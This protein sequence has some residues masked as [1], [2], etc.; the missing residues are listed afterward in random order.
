EPQRRPSALEVRKE[1]EVIGA[2][3]SAASLPSS[4]VEARETKI[5]TDMSPQEILQCLVAHGCRDITR[6]IRGRVFSW[7]PSIYSGRPG[8]SYTEGSFA[9]LCDGTKVILRRTT[10]SMQY[11]FRGA[12]KAILPTLHTAHEAYILSQCNHPN[13]HKILGVALLDHTLVISS[14]EPAPQYRQLRQVLHSKPQDL[15]RCELSTQI[16]DA[17]AYLHGKRIVHAQCI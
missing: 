17:T 3:Y 6:D 11:T 12:S 2:S 1:M 9:E 5:T 7:S 14:L 4:T 8:A 13:I 16:A 15:P 10:K